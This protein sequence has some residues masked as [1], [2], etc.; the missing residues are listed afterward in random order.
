MSSDPK[1]EKATTAGDEEVEKTAD[2]ADAVGHS[3]EKTVQTPEELNEYAGKEP[4]SEEPFFAKEMPAAFAVITAPKVC[5]PGYRLDATGKCRR[6][7]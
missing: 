2:T 4:V 5:P 7:L 6:I 1:Q 3:L